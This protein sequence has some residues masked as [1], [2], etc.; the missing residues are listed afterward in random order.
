MPSTGEWISKM[1][2]PHNGILLSSK[3]KEQTS[4]IHKLAEPQMHSGDKLPKSIGYLLYDFIYTT[5][6]KRQKKKKTK[7]YGWKTDH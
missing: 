1:L 2:H 6:W 7:T 3:N 5:I 4:D